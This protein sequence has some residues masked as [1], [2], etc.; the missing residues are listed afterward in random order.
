MKTNERIIQTDGPIL[1]Y[2]DIETVKFI[3]KCIV[4]RGREA[5][6]NSENVTFR[7]FPEDEFWQEVGKFPVHFVDPPDDFFSLWTMQF[8]QEKKILGIEGP[9]WTA[10]QGAS[11]VW[12]VLEKYTD[13]TPARFDIKM[14]KAN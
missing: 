12:L 6:H 8:A 2:A 9:L 14:I 4:R 3:V 10:E 13:S 7:F 5:L 11:D 1:T